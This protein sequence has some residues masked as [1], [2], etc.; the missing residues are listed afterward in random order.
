[1]T[2]HDDEARRDRSG[3]PLH[4]DWALLDWNCGATATGRPRLEM[5]AA[6]TRPLT[7]RLRAGG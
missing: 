1:M 3:D 2:G 7:W 6:R 5:E 4:Y